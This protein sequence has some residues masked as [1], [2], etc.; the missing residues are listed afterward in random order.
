MNWIVTILIAF[1]G[2]GVIVYIIE[3]VRKRGKIELNGYSTTLFFN[4]LPYDSVINNFNLELQFVNKSGYRVIMF[5]M[6]SQLL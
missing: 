6:I 5:C 3:L 4:P 1:F 2:G